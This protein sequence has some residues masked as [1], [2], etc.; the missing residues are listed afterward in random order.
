MKP[1]QSTNGPDTDATE[2]GVRPRSASD[3]V[4]ATLRVLIEQPG[5][6]V[7]QPVGL[8]ITGCQAGDPVVAHAR[9]DDGAACYEAKGTF[10]ADEHGRVD[11][12]RTASRAGTYVGIDP[13]GLWWSG[14][15][16]GPSTGAAATSMLLQVTVETPHGSAESV[17]ERRSLAAGATVREV[18]EVRERGVWGLYAR[19][20]G[21]GPFPGV[22]AFGGSG[23]GLGPAA[24]WAPI[25]ASHG[26]AV[27]A[28]AHFGVPGL[29]ASLVGIEVE[30]VERAV[31]WL[32]DQGEVAMDT[33]A[34]M[35]MS[36]GSELA[37][38]ASALLDH[39]GPVVAFAPSGV[40]WAGLDAGGP[41][42]APAW[43]FRGD[44]I[45]YMPIG[46]A[47]AAGQVQS[48]APLALRAAFEGALRDEAAISGAEIPV[49]RAKGPI[50]MV[51]GEDD[52]MWPSA[53]MGEIARRR[54]VSHGFAH[55]I[56]HLRYPDAGHICG[57]VPGT[58]I[59]LETRH[60]MTGGYYSFGGTRAGNAAA[61]ADSWP[62]V[63]A[64]LNDALPTERRP[65]QPTSQ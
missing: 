22:V 56:H 10:H 6:L 45:P 24:S 38:L 60:P 4:P 30:T 31:K 34:A 39:V 18:R 29:P 41:V 1:S 32:G 44:P 59:V 65:E 5:L 64:F 55:D 49:E 13:F 48:T 8:V 53:P 58:P 40:S 28:I 7:D 23:G 16:A 17:L 35:G 37:F 42:D 12:A 15:P 43:T 47:A 26:F 46:A 36:R 62:R 57:G 11:T 25:L 9:L 27:L 14:I 50:L 52:A 19:P 33:I 51:S 21:P 3:D 63:L 20:A 2:R 61:R 54:A